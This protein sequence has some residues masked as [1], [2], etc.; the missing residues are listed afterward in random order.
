MSDGAKKEEIVCRIRCRDGVLAA[1]KE[2]HFCFTQLDLAESVGGL[3]SIPTD[4]PTFPPTGGVFDI[5]T[6]EMEHIL[7][8]NTKYVA[9]PDEME[10]EFSCISWYTTKSRENLIL[11]YNMRSYDNM[12]RE[13][14]IRVCTE[15]GIDKTAL[16]L[17]K[18][19]SFEYE[20]HRREEYISFFNEK[21][22]MHKNGELN[23]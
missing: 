13:K 2:S 19:E 6:S 1:E 20:Q 15:L 3:P 17:C 14:L 23:K 21:K 9:T 8:E 11:R 12:D 5:P 22:R 4:P 18:L 7:R 10:R 16:I